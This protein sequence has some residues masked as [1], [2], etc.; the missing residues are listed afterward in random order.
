MIGR[1]RT[2]IPPTPEECH[3]CPAAIMDGS[4]MWCLYSCDEESCTYEPC[5]YV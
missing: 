3:G 5:G 4:E 2:T 1:R